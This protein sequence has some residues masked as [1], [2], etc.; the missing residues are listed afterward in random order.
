MH[1]DDSDFDE[2]DWEDQLDGM[3]GDA[4]APVLPAEASKPQD[5]L[6]EPQPA[7]PQEVAME[8]RTMRPAAP[9]RAPPRPENTRV[10]G[11][12]TYDDRLSFA[13][14]L[15]DEQPPRVKSLFAKAPPLSAPYRDW[16][17]NRLAP[18]PWQGGI[19]LDL[20]QNMM[21]AAREGHCN[22]WMML[23]NSFSRFDA[24]LGCI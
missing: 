3:S 6:I 13:R 24:G 17:N 15:L 8:H 18:V 5:E 20:S 16:I 21:S 12:V 14:R 9:T 19:H 22:V 4:A 23:A 1:G 7:Q 11:S 10:S 2:V